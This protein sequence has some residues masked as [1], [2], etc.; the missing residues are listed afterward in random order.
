MDRRRQLLTILLLG[1]AVTVFGAVVPKN[2]QLLELKAGWNLVALKGTPLRPQEE[3]LPLKPLVFDEDSCS[4]V[5]YNMTMDL[6]RGQAVW[7]YSETD[8]SISLALVSTPE[9]LPEAQ[10]SSDLEWSMIGAATNTP[11]WIEDVIQPFFRWDAP[12][13]FVQVN[14]PVADQGY[15]VQVK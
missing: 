7:L 12:K 13:G 14:E 1:V 6:Q 4:Y 10:P 2:E 5:L 11:S 3:L 15:W 9:E 8:Q